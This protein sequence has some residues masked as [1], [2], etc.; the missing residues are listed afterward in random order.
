[1]VLLTACVPYVM[2]LNLTLIVE[3]I[4]VSALFALATNL[5]VQFAGLISFGQAV[6]YGIG[7]YTIG[8]FWQH[9]HVPFM[10]TF[11]LGPVIAALV[12]FVVGALSLRARTFYFALLTLGFSQLFYSLS[13]VFYPITQGDTGIFGISLPE[14][15]QNP[16]VNYEFVLVVVAVGTFLLWYVV[17]TPFGLSLMAIRDNRMRA[18]QLGVNVFAHQLMAFVISGLFCGLSGVLFIVYEQHAYPEILNWQTSG[19][20]VLMCVLGG[21]SS[22]VGP[23]VGAMIYQVLEAWIGSVTQHWQLIVGVIILG[24]ILVYP[25][26]VARLVVQLATWGF[27]KKEKASNSQEGGEFHDGSGHR[28]VES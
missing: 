25:G 9:T 28:S 8:L 13:I 22:F 10:L 12:A 24:I 20:P 23:V 15:L 17:R 27:G 16:V 3:G 21:M 26:G 14:F 2:S 5:L 19:T 6:F 7:A 11:L 4:L 1:M 18:Q